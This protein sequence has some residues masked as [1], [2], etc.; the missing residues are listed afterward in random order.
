[1]SSRREH[2][3]VT[4]IADVSDGATPETNA[5][6]ASVQRQEMLEF[7]AEC[8]S[9]GMLTF[10][11]DGAIIS[12]NPRI[13]EILGCPN[14]VL[15][16]ST[17]E[18]L[19]ERE[20]VSTIYRHARALANLGCSA[21]PARWV[22]V[23]GRHVSGEDR[24]LDLSLACVRCDPSPICMALARDV[25]DIQRT[26]ESL[27][28]EQVRFHTFFQNSSDALFIHDTR[29][30]ILEANP[31]AIEVLGYSLSDL[32][33]MRVKDLHGDADNKL[34]PKGNM[35]IGEEVTF[36]TEFQNASGDIFPVRIRSQKVVLGEDA[37]LIA[38]VKDLRRE[39][40]IRL[41][42]EQAQQ[43]EAMG[44]MA[45]ALS[46]DFNNML[47]V[48]ITNALEL[49]E[50]TN[51]TADEK[52]ML[53]DLHVA[54]D[55]A[56]TL[57]SR[58]LGI[59]RKQGTLPG[60]CELNSCIDSMSGPLR[61]LLRESVTL[62][63]NLEKSDIVIA[64]HESQVTQILTNLVCNARDAITGAGTITLQTRRVQHGH[65]IY[66]MLSVADDGAGMSDEVQSRIFEPLFTTKSPTSGTGLGLA[67]VQAILDSQCG[68]VE[69]DSTLGEGTTFR[70][71]FPLE[72]ETSPA[73]TV[74]PQSGRSLRALVVDD[75]Q[76]VRKTL[77]RLLARWGF[78][79]DSAED[80]VMGAEL[81]AAHPPGHY[82]LLM[83]DMMMP[84]MS[85][86]ELCTRAREHDP[87]LPIIVLTAYSSETIPHDSTGLLRAVSK[88]V[89]PS[90]LR[91]VVTSLLGDEVLT[92]GAA[93]S[94]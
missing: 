30:R 29:G 38:T 75:M 65:D 56:S 42:L 41:Q 66:G 1:M 94:N 88:P 70:L 52:E 84:K 76:G 36:K 10:G 89:Q 60:T 53:S 80:G 54:A 55:Q 24:I 40:I 3:A 5:D 61:G 68:T 20:D 37:V 7:A 78:E 26:R 46:H 58:L 67:S 85:G 81:L 51:L 12:A 47:M 28:R 48:V 25:T 69:V 35:S 14:A 49:Q 27:A 32:R 23:K 82:A 6:L 11:L 17:L 33:D 16:N 8:G 18:D 87:G 50:S 21:P 73:Q 39:E 79:A 86:A 45:G 74:G 62:E 83:T 43:L 93:E 91:G 2:K 64:L 34:A 71:T 15:C 4:T 92:A 59:T 44:R 57:A 77:T 13:S 19:F 31:N 90:R 22:R 9:D 63:T 72:H